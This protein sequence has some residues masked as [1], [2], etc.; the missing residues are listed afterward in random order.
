MDI[1]GIVGN[2]K[3]GVGD[4]STMEPRLGKTGEVLTG[5]AHGGYYEGASRGF[6]FIVN[7]AVA[8]VAPGTVLSTTPPLALW[9]PPASGI[10]IVINK[11]WMGYISGTLGA[12][13]VI[14]AQ[15]AQT[16]TPSGGTTL[17]PVSTIIGNLTKPRASA[18]QG[19]TVAATP[20]IVRSTGIILSAFA[21]GASQPQQPTLDDMGGEIVLAP[22]NCA[23]LQGQAGAGTSP[24][25]TLGFGWEEV[26]LT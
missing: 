24:L 18:F 9:N 17:T 7:T 22:G 12:G 26:P 5:K 20:T 15:V 25:V 3:D 23:V 2:K 6:T 21:G 19:S 14:L 1:K 4:G 16:T 13:H 10:L 8:G 11:L